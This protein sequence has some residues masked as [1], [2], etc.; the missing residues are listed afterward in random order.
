[1][2]NCLQFEISVLSIVMT[3]LNLLSLSR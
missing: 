1:M 2:T 3:H